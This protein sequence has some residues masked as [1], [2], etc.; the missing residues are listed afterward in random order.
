MRFSKPFIILILGLLSATA[1]AGLSYEE[2]LDVLRPLTRGID[3][4]ES[5]Y[6]ESYAPRKHTYTSQ[7]ETYSPELARVHVTDALNIKMDIKK[8]RERFR[9]LNYFN[10]MESSQ[11][12]VTRKKEEVAKELEEIRKLIRFMRDP[13][14]SLYSPWSKRD[15]SN[16]KMSLQA[17]LA[18][19]R[20]NMG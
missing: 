19:G 9:P 14:D 11:R 15:A 16:I 18:I 6:S 8:I 5:L 3:E 7:V 20:L 1:Q 10:W 4:A 13:V 2:M 17:A 12:E